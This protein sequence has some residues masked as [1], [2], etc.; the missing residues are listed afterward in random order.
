M[1]D[2]PGDNTTVLQELIDRLRA[3]DASA[4]RELLEKACE[5]LRRLTARMLR[6]SFP[7]VSERHE[8]DSVVHDAWLRLM[9]TLES[10]QPPTV[11]D[12][13]RLAA[14]K[15]RQVLLDMAGKQRK[16]GQRMQIGLGSHSSALSAPAD[17]TFDPARLALWTEL[18]ERVGLLKDDERSVFEMHYYL[19]LTQTEIAKLLD[20]H[21]R[22][23]SYLW[24]AA[25]DRLAAQLE[26]LAP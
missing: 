22:K 14:H 8:V 24:M 4:R 6:E 1:A 15:I 20:V 2:Q 10:V 5:R 17:Q 11:L 3:G 26:A 9:Q 23:V 16:D 25:T 12:F 19:G 13:F 18:H 7:A 21:P